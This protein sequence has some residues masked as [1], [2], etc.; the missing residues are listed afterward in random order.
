MNNY[1]D[2][3]FYTD[4]FKGSLSNDIFSFYIVKASR[5]IDRN[6]NRKLTNDVIHSLSEDDQNNI[7]YVAC[8]LVDSLYKEDNDANSI[9]IDGVSISKGYYSNTNNENDI[10]KNILNNL[11]HELIRYL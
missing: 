5:Y 8:E 4:E 10:K 3:Q 11:P 2:Y 1:A 7:K 9:S 6:I